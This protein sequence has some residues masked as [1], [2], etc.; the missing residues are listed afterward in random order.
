MNKHIE[1]SKQSK[2]L[3]F[4]GITAAALALAVGGPHAVKADSVS[5]NTLAASS[6]TR[7]AKTF[8]SKSLWPTLPAS[9]K[10]AG[11]KNKVTT[12]SD[13]TIDD[14][15]PDKNLQQVVAYNLYG[16]PNSVSKITKEDLSKL[17]T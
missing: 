5:G 16:N 11:I 13:D 14:W 2:K 10:T 6:L 9:A 8:P 4:S 1:L 7:T 3:L 12:K 15:M 17:K